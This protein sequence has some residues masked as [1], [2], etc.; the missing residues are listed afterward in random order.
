MQRGE[1][2]HRQA[3]DMRLLFADRIEHGEDVIGGA[4]LRIG[5]HMLG[6]I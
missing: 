3:H 6:H 2:A 1:A 4:G 5:R